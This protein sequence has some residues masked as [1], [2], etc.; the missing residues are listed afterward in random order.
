MEL[1]KERLGCGT[2]TQWKSSS[3][4]LVSVVIGIVEA[5][6]LIGK[7]LSTGLV[8]KIG[9]VNDFGDEQLSVDLL[10]EKIFNEWAE[11]EASIKYTSSEE[12]IDLK[13]VH[14]DGKFIVCWDPLDGSSI[15]D[16]NW[17]VGSIVGVWE[18]GPPGDDVLLGKTGRQLVCSIMAVYGPRINVLLGL[19][20]EVFDLIYIKDD[21]YVLPLSPVIKKAGA[22]IFSPANIR[23]TNDLMGYKA[24]VDYWLEKKYTLRY[25]G[26][27]VP[28]VY[29]IF[30]KGNGIFSNP[31]SENAP[32]K[33][34]LV[35]E[36]APIAYLI[37]HANGRTSDGR[38]SILD[39]PIENMDQRVPFC[40]GTAEEVERFETFLRNHGLP[41]S[42]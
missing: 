14:K 26:G 5:C 25:T 27:L 42:S 35:Y 10:A 11:G 37:E 15:I 23:A 40:G 6:A 21:F 16:C 7:K 8:T 36:V 33:L 4:A 32:A 28:D 29:Q 39:I 13:E 2:S 17:S 31:A 20:G 18:S 41:L 34:R 9:S 22:R 1:L 38:C 3:D 24:L 19:R 30:Q 12:S